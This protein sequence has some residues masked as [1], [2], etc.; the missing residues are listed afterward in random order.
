MKVGVIRRHWL[1]R[2]P[3]KEP[4]ACPQW[5]SLWMPGT[6]KVQNM[7]GLWSTTLRVI[8]TPTSL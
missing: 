1:T 8:I 4:A 6:I 7:Q 2:L 3:L 5:G